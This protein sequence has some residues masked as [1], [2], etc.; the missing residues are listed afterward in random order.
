MGKICPKCGK[1]S[2]DTVKF[3][4]SCGSAFIAPDSKKSTGVSGN[5]CIIHLLN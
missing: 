4:E 1:E 3:C 2:P 5:N